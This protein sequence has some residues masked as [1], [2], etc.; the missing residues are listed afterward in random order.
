MATCCG[1]MALSGVFFLAGCADFP[2]GSGGGVISA[3]RRGD[4]A[5]V[6]ALLDK[7]ANANAA[8]GEGRTA[9]MWAANMGRL[10]FFPNSLMDR[11]ME[12]HRKIWAMSFTPVETFAYDEGSFYST[13]A[14]GPPGGYV[15][16][17]RALVSHGAV[18]GAEWKGL[19]ALDLAASNGSRELAQVLLDGGADARASLGLVRDLETA[20]F[21]A[22]RGAEIDSRGASGMTPLMQS[23]QRGDV[24]LALWLVEKGADLMATTEGG[25]TPAELARKSKHEDLA[26]MLADAARKPPAEQPAAAR[27]QVSAAPSSDVDAPTFKLR[28]RP[29]DWALVVGIEN[30][31]KNLPKADYAE[32]DAAAVRAHVIALGVPEQNVVLLVGQDASQ[33]AIKSYLEDYLP[34]NVGPQ[35]RVYFYYSGHGAPDP[36]TGS[37]YLVPWEADPQFITTQGLPLDQL[38]GD[39]AKLKAKEVL[40]AMDSCF[41]GAGGR[42]VLRKGARPLV[43]VRADSFDPGARMTILTAAASNQIAGFSEEQGHGLFTYYLLKGLDERHF[44]AQSLYE[45]LKPNVEK[46]ARRQNSIQEPTLRGAALTLSEP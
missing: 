21:L 42:S 37:A 17:A 19:T 36:E 13:P 20:K 41:S 12:T 3:A 27:T 14:K 22:E 1:L 31:H 33:S 7:G 35:S 5:K 8:D 15:E 40:V 46:A 28:Q 39:L 44:D 10:P 16:A 34:K 29:D 24:R 4:A 6:A 32:R 38:Y 26:G 25:D 45:S 30:Y 43:T 9:L 23:A 18:V 11:G 2:L